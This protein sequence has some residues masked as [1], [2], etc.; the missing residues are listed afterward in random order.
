MFESIKNFILRKGQKEDDSYKNMRTWKPEF[1]IFQMPAGIRQPAIAPSLPL[2][3][4]IHDSSP[5]IKIATLR[6]R[7]SIF[8]RGFE[9]IPKYVCPVCKREF[10]EKNKVSVC[11]DCGA[12]IPEPNIKQQL[13]AKIFFKRVNK[14]KQQILSLLK[15]VEDDVNIFDDAYLVA[16][17][18]YVQNDAGDIIFTSL[19]EIVRGNPITMRMVSTENGEFGGKWWT[20][21]HHR[22]ILEEYAEKCCPKCGRKLYEVHFVSTEGGGESAKSH[23]I[24]GEVVHFSK[25]GPSGLYGYSPIVTLWE[26]ILTLNHMIKY[27][28]QSYTVQHLPK[29]VLAIKTTNPESAY[30]FWR[31]VDDKL[32]K[33]PHYIPKMFIEGEGAGTGMEFVRFMDT[34]EEMQFIPVRDEIRRTIAAIYGV[35]NIF[36]GDTSGVG[37]LNSESEQV[38]I[39]NMAA[40][41]A[42]TMYNDIVL[43]AIMVWLNIEDWE[44]RLKSPFEENKT[45]ELDEKMKET[46]I[47][48]SMLAMGFKVELTEDGHFR[49]SGIAQNPNQQQ[50][51]QGQNPL[52]NPFGEMQPQNNGGL[53][54]GMDLQSSP[55][56]QLG[57]GVPQLN[58]AKSDIVKKSKR[59]LK[60]NV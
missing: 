17:K 1:D 2:L 5:P 59:K 35:T 27:V 40:E 8:R 52:M 13:R 34:L 49:Y 60:P 9:W 3:K 55:E 36:I 37:G 44:F 56:P 38:Q 42:M 48:Q 14:N 20:C 39:T 11:P 47:A 19:K 41:S 31:D 53:N 7:E 28:Y 54:E 22:D 23:Y 32:Q 25:Y 15:Q 26:Y 33:D 6:L 24:D 50:G 18:E 46:Q 12:K 10:H 43:P 58:E 4:Y 16:I 51:Q 29:G 30:Q 45:L 57:S 21:L